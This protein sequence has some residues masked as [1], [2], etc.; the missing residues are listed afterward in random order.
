MN[1]IT[2]SLKTI[3]ILAAALALTLSARLAVGGGATGEGP[4]GLCDDNCAGSKYSTPLYVGTVILQHVPDSDVVIVYTPRGLPLRQFV[5]LSGLRCKI[6]LP[7]S[8]TEFYDP[9]FFPLADSGI[10]FSELKEEDLKGLCIAAEDLGQFASDCIFE[11]GAKLETLEISG[12]QPLDN[13]VT[14]Y[15]ANIILITRLL[16]EQSN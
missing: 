14:R 7:S 8:G 9:L 15:K 1:A 10:D 3:G 6:A 16:S 12:L 5:P 11:L 2:L 4:I 13:P